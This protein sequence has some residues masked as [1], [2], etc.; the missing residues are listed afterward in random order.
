MKKK[1]LKE[2]L[3]LDIETVSTVKNFQEL[4]K[5]MQSQWVKKCNYLRNEENLT[6]EELYFQKGAIYAEF[7]KVITIALGL[8]QIDENNELKLRVKTIHN[9]NEKSL[10][11][12][13][14]ELIEKFDS[15]HLKLCAHNGKE[16]DYPYLCR[17]M[18]LN[19]I[20]IPNALDIRNRKPWEIQHLDTLDM[21]KFGDRKNFTSLELMT[22]IFDIESSKDDIDGS[23]VN[24]IYYHQNGLERIAEYCS[25]D[26]IATA[27]LFLKM[28]NMNTITKANITFVS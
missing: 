8:F 13:F 14:K 25:N 7:G 15:D 16:F 5:R 6:E 3:V 19:G 9:H 1:E 17:R 24:E 10:L 2:V 26:V 11:E 27:Q 22:T 4:P 21:W 23:Q 20:K 18:L 28:N 12:E